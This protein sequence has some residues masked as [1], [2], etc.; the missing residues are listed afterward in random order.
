[1]TQMPAVDVAYRCTLTHTHTDC[2]K[3]YLVVSCNKS[4]HLQVFH[5]KFTHTFLCNLACRQSANQDRHTV[6]FALGV[7]APKFLKFFSHK[8]F[9]F[10]M[11]KC[12]VH[13]GVQ[14]CLNST[15]LHENVYIVFITQVF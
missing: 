8:W 10:P 6:M 2:P 5:E 11:I 9:T 14:S 1:M 7:V 15:R 3:I 13:S 12:I 4:C